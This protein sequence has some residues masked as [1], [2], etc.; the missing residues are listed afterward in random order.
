MSAHVVLVAIRSLAPTDAC[1][2]QALAR[3]HLTSSPEPDRDHVAW[4]RACEDLGLLDLAAREWRLALERAPADVEAALRLAHLLQDQ[5]ELRR[6]LR[7]LEDSQRAGA[8]DAEIERLALE[9]ASD[10]AEDSDF[11]ERSLAS[12]APG[13]GPPAHAPSPDAPREPTP[14]PARPTAELPSDAGL[15][16]FLGLFAG[17]EDV[18]ARQWADGTGSSG[19]SPVHEPLTPR[20]L[21]DHLS[22]DVTL[23]VYPV[24]LDGT[25]TFF[26]LDLDIRKRALQAARGDLAAARALQRK[27]AEAARRAHER[28]QGLG[29]PALLEDSGYKGRHLWFFLREP[30]P[31]STIHAF[32]NQLLADL[33]RELDGELHFEFFP[34]QGSRDPQGKGLG[35]LIKLPLGL[36]RVNGRR[37]RFLRPDGSNLD[38]PFEVLRG[39]EGISRGQ[40]QHALQELR[41][42]AAAAPAESTPLEVAKDV[43][44]RDG[45]NQSPALPAAPPPPAPWT[46]ADFETDPEVAAVLQGCP[47][48]RSLR[49]RVEEHGRLD[50]DE[51]VVVTYTLGHLPRGVPAVNHLLSRCADVPL[52][53]HLQSRLSG[54]PMSCPKIRKRIPGVTSS[55]AC[56]CTFPD[57]P[58]QYPTPVLH[59]AHLPTAPA[60]SEAARP[61][62]P[63]EDAVRRWAQL[64][65][66]RLQLENEVSVARDDLLVRLASQPGSTVQLPEGEMSL[67]HQAGV[68]CLQWRP[69]SG[70]PEPGSTDADGSQAAAP[71]ES[72]LTSPRVQ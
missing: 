38:A 12:Q 46:D 67:V 44:V 9:L 19:Y 43:A 66:R 26:A 30:E 5:G 29:L 18:H 56:N 49:K 10:I 24:R 59:A 23:G 8:C 20:R 55:L 32:G 41:V 72:F 64:E 1:K 13:P 47:V 53:R 57:A 31:A 48:L 69:A 14:A 4:A 28:V 3:E 54:S 60:K 51:Q 33:S 62:I 11:D 70:A 22:G 52:N 65:R 42:A 34:K 21:R 61:S 35:N 58:D 45:T 25:V 50:Y 2:A 63:L 15:V 40:L 71:A 27:V 36:H 37:S 39:V 68:P 17:R 6:A 7:T 16:R